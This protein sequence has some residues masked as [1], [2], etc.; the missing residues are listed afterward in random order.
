MALGSLL[1]LGACSDHHTEAP[2]APPVALRSLEDF[3]C[4]NTLADTLV[5]H[6]VC[7]DTEQRIVPWTAA[8]S[9]Y[10][11]VAKRVWDAL[12]A[13]PDLP[14][15]KPTYYSSALFVGGPPDVW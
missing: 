14:N 10:A 15:G 2:V 9:A 8:A 6:R 1:T 3:G 13:V 7:V 4:R 5:F 11:D 12:V